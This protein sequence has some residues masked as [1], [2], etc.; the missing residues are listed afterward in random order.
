[1][2]VRWAVAATIL[3]VGL[4]VPAGSHAGGLFLTEFGTEDVAW[5]GPAGRRGHRTRPPCSRTRLA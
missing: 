5:Q 3:T 2:A 4:I 1:M